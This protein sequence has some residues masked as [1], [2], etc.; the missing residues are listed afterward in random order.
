MDFIGEETSQKID[1]AIASGFVE[2]CG[3]VVRT[4]DSQ[5]REP[6]FESSCCCFKDWAIFF[7]PHYSSSFGCIN[8]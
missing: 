3:I 5:S 8:E 6:G 1:I 4:L 7:T 2:C